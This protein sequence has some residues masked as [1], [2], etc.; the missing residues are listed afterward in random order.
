MESINLNNIDIPFKLVKKENK[1]TYFYFKKSGYIQINQSKYQS[2]KS[3][4]RYMNQNADKF[5]LKYKIRCLGNDADL[6]KYQYLGKVYKIVIS[7]IQEIT[8][9]NDN[10]IL[11]APTTDRNH[12]SYFVFQKRN[13]LKMLNDLKRKY[14]NNKYININA[15]TLKTRY[16][17]TR[18]GSCNYK[19]QNI[20]INLNLIKYE[21]KFIEYV[22][23]H[24][25]SHLIHPNHSSNFYDLLKKLC[26]N[27]K[28]LKNELKEIYR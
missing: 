8:I 19:K 23:L 21:Y 10:L 27:Y 6:S 17:K 9:D 5:A 26:P 16:T 28:E 13:M 25:I 2:K 3:V 18:H 12:N 1:N 7:N 22:F 14:C 4:M 24:E 20:N 11:H 15:I